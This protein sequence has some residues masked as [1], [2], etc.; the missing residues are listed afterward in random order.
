M[1]VRNVDDIPLALISEVVELEVLHEPFE[2][3]LLVYAIAEIDVMP[4]GITTVAEAIVLLLDALVNRSLYVLLILLHALNGAMELEYL[5]LLPSVNTTSAFSPELCPSAVALSVAPSS[6]A[7]A[8]TYHVVFKS[9][10][11]SAVAE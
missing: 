8:G 4:D 9:P 7:S 10:F 1:D 2:M 6:S 5:S 3:L 11:A